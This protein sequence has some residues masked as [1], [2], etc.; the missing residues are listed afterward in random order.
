MHHTEYN[1]TRVVKYLVWTF[2]LAYLIQVGAARIYNSG[3]TMIGQL[4][5]AA[6]MFVPTLG[7]LLSGSSLREMGWKL[8][9]RKNI[10]VIL[11]AWFAPAILTAVGAALYFLVFPGHFD[12]SGSSLAVTAGEEAMEQM[13]ALAGRPAVQRTTLYGRV[14]S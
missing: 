8:Q 14:G 7:V 13:A 11:I 5:V 6:M 3:N 2:V 9:I 4:V 10:K 1:K 12:M